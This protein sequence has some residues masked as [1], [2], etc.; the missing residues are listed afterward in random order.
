MLRQMGRISLVLGVLGWVVLVLTLLKG[1]LDPS[2]TL[3]PWL[4]AA[5]TV[6]LCTSVLALCFAVAALIRRERRITASLGLALSVLFLLYF[7]GFGFVF[8]VPFR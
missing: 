4:R 3:T 6:S 7:T 1:G 2:P 5:T 8:L